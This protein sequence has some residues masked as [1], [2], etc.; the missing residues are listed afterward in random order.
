MLARQRAAAG[1]PAPQWLPAGSQELL[2]GELP[3]L[4]E[5]APS[6]ARPARG[7]LGFRPEWEALALT[8]ESTPAV[9]C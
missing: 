8:S 9:A 2:R 3:G 6:R 4:R 7:L 5:L 1:L